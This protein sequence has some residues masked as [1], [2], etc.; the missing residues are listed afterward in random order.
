MV[1]VNHA[2]KKNS[3]VPEEIKLKSLR[4]LFV[5]SLSIETLREDL[6][7]YFSLFGQVVNAYIIYDPLTKKSKSI[8]Y[9]KQTS[10]M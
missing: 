10:A 4:K 7:D 3:E 9:I 2:V 8:P 6:I 5:G 1:E